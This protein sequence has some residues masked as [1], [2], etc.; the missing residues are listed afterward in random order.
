MSNYTRH[1]NCWFQFISKSSDIYCFK[2]FTWTQ[3][4]ILYT[5]RT[6]CNAECHTSERSSLCLLSVRGVCGSV[7]EHENWGCMNCGCDIHLT[8]DI[9][10]ANEISELAGMFKCYSFLIYSPPIYLASTFHYIYFYLFL[11]V[12]FPFCNYLY[13]SCSIDFELY[14]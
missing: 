9:S 12:T 2:Q 13:M 10:V 5:T 8:W 3:R 4:E 6:M 7:R 1:H 11:F 14:L